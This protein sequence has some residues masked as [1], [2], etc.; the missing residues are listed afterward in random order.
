MIPPPCFLPPS[1]GLLVLLPLGRST[2]TDAGGPFERTNHNCKT[3]STSLHQAQ[4]SQNMQGQLRVIA[5]IASA[6]GRYDFS[7]AHLNQL[8]GIVPRPFQDWLQTAWM[9]HLQSPT[10]T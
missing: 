3:M 6:E 7:D 5:L 10:P 4:M 8:I 2:E 1:D 9:G